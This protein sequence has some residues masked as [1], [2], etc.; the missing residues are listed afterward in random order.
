VFVL[1]GA[2]SA[3]QGALFFARY[4]A[5]VT[6]IVRKPGLQPAMSYYLTDRITNTPNITVMGRSEIVAAHGNGH[7]ERLDIRNPHF[8]NISRYISEHAMKGAAVYSPP[9]A[10]PGAL[11]PGPARP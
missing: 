7:L 11:A 8:N 6:I 5:Q 1:G 9:Q 10:K 2:N 4:A 3:G